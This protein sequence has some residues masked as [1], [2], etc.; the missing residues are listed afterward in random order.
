MK[1]FAKGKQFHND[2]KSDES[3]LDQ[4]ES[5][6]Y[7]KTEQPSSHESGLV[8]SIEETKTD[9]KPELPDEFS[10][11][12]SSKE[13]VATLAQQL[14]DGLR[15]VLQDMETGKKN[16]EV[17][18]N[19]VLEETQEVS[20]A[21]Q[22]ASTDSRPSN[23]AKGADEEASQ[24]EEDPLQ[25]EN[26]EPV[27]EAS[28]STLETESVDE[29]PILAE[30]E[31]TVK[32][33]TDSLESEAG[34]DTKTPSVT[35]ASMAEAIR[36]SGEKASDSRKH[37]NPIDDETLL[38]EIY[39]LMGD[40]QPKNSTAKNGLEKLDEDTKVRKETIEIKPI[41]EESFNP[42]PVPS[43]AITTQQS[44]DRNEYPADETELEE[45]PDTHGAPGWIKGIFLLLVS[46]LLS[47]MTFYAVGTDLFGKLF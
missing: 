7:K 11:E 12:H 35:Y 28:D 23:D 41:Q 14:S 24:I 6:H 25:L 21:D 5:L 34:K 46:L 37:R 13:E 38:A 9:T 15:E 31:E 2:Q 3:K 1:L 40:S 29:E 32:A 42:V 22:N 39:A 16:N 43:S 45:Y 10:I 36:Q 19:L 8:L 33:V 17:P 47:G 20:E 30:V 18:E 26:D 27:Q 4:N 44:D